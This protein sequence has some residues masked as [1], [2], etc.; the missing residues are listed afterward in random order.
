LIWRFRADFS[1]LTFFLFS[2]STFVYIHFLK[3]LFNWLNS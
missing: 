1:S 3:V 2:S